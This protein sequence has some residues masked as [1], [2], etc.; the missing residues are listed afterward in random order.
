MSA[1]SGSE[2]CYL[3]VATDL[4]HFEVCKSAPVAQ[5]LIFNGVIY[6]RL[7]G[8]YYAWLRKRIDAAH[9]ACA[10]GK[11]NPKDYDETL[12]A[13]SAIDEWAVAKVGRDFLKKAVKGFTGKGYRGPGE[14]P[15][16]T[17]LPPTNK[18][19]YGRQTRHR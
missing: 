19:S 9:E 4:R 8:N 5:D 14:K 12:A 3:Y 13:F 2:D 7:D 18:R 1:D 17:Q 16:E 10:E 15:K 6:R 11:C